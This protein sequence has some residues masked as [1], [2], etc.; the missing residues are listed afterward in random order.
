VNWLHRPVVCRHYFE[1]SSSSGDP[2]LIVGIVILI[3]VMLVVNV[4]TMVYWQNPDDKNE[5]ILVRVIILVGLQLASMTVLMIPVDVANNAGNFLCDGSSSSAYCGGLDMTFCWKFLFCVIAFYLVIPLPFAIF[6]YEADDGALTGL[7]ENSRLTTAFQYECALIA[8]VLIMLLSSYY[9]SVPM[10]LP[11]DTY[12]VS[13]SLGEEVTYQIPVAGASPYSYINLNLT[14]AQVNQYAGAF[15]SGSI[16]VLITDFAVYMIAFAG[17]IGWWLF[18]IFAGA[19]FIALP[20]DLLL[21]FIYRPR[22]LPPDQ[23]ATEELEIQTRAKEV[24]SLCDTL[25]KDRAD[26]ANSSASRAER[27]KRAVT[28][29]LEVNKLAQMVYVLERDLDYLRECKTIGEN[30][31]PLIPLGNLLGGLL[32]I[33][34]SILW[35]AQIIMFTQNEVGFLNNYLMSFDTWFPMFGNISYAIFSIYLFFATVKGCFKIGMKVVCIKIHPMVPGKTFVNSFLFNVAIILV[36]TIPVV[37]LCAG[38]FASYARYSDV[39]LMFNIEINY[40]EFYSLFYT[41][42]VFIIILLISAFFH[43]ITTILWPRDKS[44]SISSL[45]DAVQNRTRLTA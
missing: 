36:C 24:T 6:Y 22:R 38:A 44:L 17:W 3:C 7:Q 34:I 5:S 11:L 35:I 15:E 28:D 39:Y 19:G 30:Y 1:M 25:R 2:L 33:L 23:L 26:F 40:M 29:R 18:A 8:S 14:I 20:G 13:F 4:Y 42:H 43:L 16:L 21:S 27:S 37:Q 9:S 10:Q 32:G 41:N 45:K 12:E 31:N